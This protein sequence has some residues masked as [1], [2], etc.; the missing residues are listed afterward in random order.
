MPLVN[1]ANVDRVIAIIREQSVKLVR[2]KATIVQM[3][4]AEPIQRYE[5]W[6]AETRS[7]INENIK[8]EVQTFD[9]IESKEH[10]I[11]QQLAKVQYEYQGY[12]AYFP[13]LIQALEGGSVKVVTAPTN[14]SRYTDR[15]LMERTIALAKKS[16]NE[17]GNVA[18]KVGAIVSRDREI[19]GEAYRGELAP[20]NHAEF[21]LLQSKLSEEVLAGATLF[22]TLEPC[23]SRNHPKRPCAQWIID[24]RIKKVF[25]GI[26]DRN[27]NIRGNGEIQLQEAGIEVE[28]FDGDLVKKIEELDRE[29]L[30]HIRL[31]KRTHAET[32]DPVEEGAVGPNGYPIGFTSNGDKVE[33]IPAE[34]EGYPN[35]AWPMILRRNDN[36]ILETCQEMWDKVWW[37]RHQNWLYRI[38]IGEEPLTEAQK[39]LLETAK[40]AAKRI[41]DKYG[42]ENLGW[43]DV[44]W[45]IVQ[46]KLSALAWVMG[47]EWEGSLDT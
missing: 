26:L 29:F 5:R 2:I 38:K 44:E 47:S 7:L 13:L 25:I 40:I 23:T 21:T 16:V 19:I 3:C 14:E 28:H 1:D 10:P 31:K 11:K 37:N 9:R 18:P 39:P 33:W 20:G 32:T 22:T 24:R 4:G 15:E 42:V 8:D 30:R 43:D 34:E 45:G 27:P 12:M 17:P 36:D 35:E 41:E 6:R 46:G